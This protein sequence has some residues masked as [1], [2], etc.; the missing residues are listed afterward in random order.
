M[1]LTVLL[2]VLREEFA[3]SLRSQVLLCQPHREMGCVETKPWLQ[4]RTAE[5]QEDPGT[6]SCRR[7]MQALNC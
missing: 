6:S 7:E 3:V 1:V 4:P 2:V 5:E